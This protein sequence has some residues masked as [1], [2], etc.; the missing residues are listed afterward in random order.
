[1]ALPPQMIARDR[2]LAAR[3][4]AAP[5][6][7]RRLRHPGR[8]RPAAHRGDLPAAPRRRPLR[9]GPAPHRQT[10]TAPHQGRPAAHPTRTGRRGHRLGRQQVEID[11]RGTHRDPPGVARDVLWYRVHKRRLR[12]PGHRARPR[13]RRRPDDFFFTTDLAA[14]GAEIATGYAGRWPI[15][16]TYRDVKQDL[17]GEDPQSW[18]GKGPARA[19]A[20]SLW[21]HAAIWC[22]YLSTH[23]DRHAP[24]RPG[25]GTAT[26]TPPASPTP[27]PPCAETCGTTNY[28]H[29][30]Q[31]RADNAKITEA[32]LDALA[33][34]A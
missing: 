26:S 23:T 5:A 18:K 12:A 11:Q 28:S 31:P 24:G 32:L 30:G 6:R 25:P 34:A 20:L 33:Y 7:R 9:T 2:R 29:V 27:S 14:T 17:G 1:M 4:G 22:W 13:R 15:E 21:L 8:R 3:P 16:V 10:R 19:A